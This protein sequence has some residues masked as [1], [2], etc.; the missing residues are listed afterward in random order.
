MSEAVHTPRKETAIASWR[1]HPIF[2]ALIAT[3]VTVG[4]VLGCV[5][6][7]HPRAA[8]QSPATSSPALTVTIAAPRRMVW[9]TSLQ[10]PGPIAPWQEASIGTQIGGY[11][12]IE[13]RVNVGDRVQKGQ[14]L[15][16]LN[17]ELLLADEAQLVASDDQARA[18]L[19]RVLSLR[20]S[21]A[22]SDQDILQFQTGAKTADALLAAKRVQL[23]Y[24]EV[25][26]PDDGTIS[27]RPATLGAVV[28]V[29]QELF[30]LILQ[31]RLEW[32]GELT[33]AQLTHIAIGQHVALHLPDGGTAT[34]TVRQIAPSLG[35][36]SRLGVVYAD[37]MPGSSARAGMYANGQ[38]IFGEANALVIPAESV[39]IRDGRSYVLKLADRSATPHV[40]LLSIVTGRRRGDDVEIVSGLNE[41]DRVVVAGAGFLNDGDVVRVANGAPAQDATQ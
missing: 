30:R 35:A 26:A 1:A 27:A 25:R 4:A 28:P 23:R 39:V 22:V 24:T 3:I 2:Y 41:S 31:D 9:P 8:A 7:E 11:Q 29:G 13:V 19:R 18:N 33:A 36:Q 10:A 5:A 34:A 32:R 6:L 37:L 16:R 21:G 38:I 17:P 20:G 15:A 14:V 12:L 40:V